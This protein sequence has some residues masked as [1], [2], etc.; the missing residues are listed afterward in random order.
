MRIL[1]ALTGANAS[2]DATESFLPRKEATRI[3]ETTLGTRS[4]MDSV[5]MAYASKV[6]QYNEAITR[7]GLKPNMADN[8]ASLFPEEK[9]AE[10]AMMW[11]MVMKMME[12]TPPAP[13]S[14][15][16][17]YR[18]STPVSKLIIVKAKAYLEAAFLKFV[19]N[20]VYS[21]LQQA[22]LGGIP[23]TYHLIKSFLKVRISVH[24]P[25]LEDGIVDGVPVWPLI[26][27][28]L[29]SGDISAAI[30]AASDAGHGLAEVK[31][32]LEEIFSSADK[33]LTPHAENI[34]KINYKRSLR[35]TTDP[36]KRAVFCVLAA[37]DPNDEHSEV[38]TSLDD[39]IWLKILQI[40]EKA[41]SNEALTLSDFQKQMSE[42]YGET[43][44]NAYDQPFLYFQVLFLTGQFELAFEFLF[45]VDRFRSHSV[46]MCLAMH[47]CGL[48]LLPNNIQ[49]PL[50]TQVSYLQ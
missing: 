32:L 46:H 24:T 18:V 8:L 23:G 50:I 43:H 9:D 13:N 7:G 47:E 21:N 10:V 1:T 3:H 2:S 36:Y 22:E 42:D 4:C 45:R 6:G 34:V 30:Q 35:S 31:K 17:K 29:R 28:C 44:F 37:C 27:Y 19:K 41:E 14:D 38:A 25:G 5:E 16:V 12:I 49:A 20:T 39:Y 26:Y 33:R 40:R 11:E 48:L 15:A